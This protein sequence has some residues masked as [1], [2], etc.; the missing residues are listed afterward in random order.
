MASRP[1]LGVTSQSIIDR[2]KSMTSPAATMA[3]SPSTGAIDNLLNGYQKAAAI[4][5]PVLDGNQ[6]DPLQEYLNGGT[7]TPNPTSSPVSN[8]IGGI[9]N[10]DAQGL[11]PRDPNF[12]PYGI[13]NDDNWHNLGG[14]VMEHQLNSNVNPRD[15]ALF[16]MRNNG[17][18][19]RNAEPYGANGEYTVSYNYPDL[20]AYKKDAARTS[21]L[22]PQAYNGNGSG[23]VGGDSGGGSSGISA[24]SYNPGVRSMPSPGM[25]TS[26][27]GSYMSTSPGLLQQYAASAQQPQQSNPGMGNAIQA[28]LAQLRSPRG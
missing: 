3:P 24:G 20:E 8:S 22:P 21:Q 25:M 28:R 19:L 23:Y 15:V 2:L 16:W 6:A 14:S 10:W 27:T 18:H 13:K 11:P 26:P 4:S 12:Q 7:P 1:S 9:P 17:E 5:D